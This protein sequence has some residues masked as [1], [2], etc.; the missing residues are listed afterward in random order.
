MTATRLWLLS[1]LA[2]VGLLFA[3]GCSDA[4]RTT[5][6]TLA[7]GIGDG[8]VSGG[9]GDGRGTDPSFS[10]ASGAAP[11]SDDSGEVR[12]SASMGPSVPVDPPVGTDPPQV[13]VSP[14]TLTAGVWDDNRNFD[15]FRDYRTDVTQLGTVG[16]PPF[17]DQQH[18]DAWQASAAELRSHAKLDISLIVDTTGSMGDEMTYLQTE[19]DAMSQQIEAQF[20][21]SQQRWSLVV[22]RDEGDEYVTRWFDFRSDPADFRTHLAAQSANGGGDFPEA[23]DA[24]LGVMNQLA[25]RTDADTARLAFWV[26]DAPHHEENADVLAAGVLNAQ[27]LGIHLYPVASSGVDELTELSMRSAAQLTYGRYIFLTDDSGVGG[28]HKE[29]TIPCYF[30]TQLDHAIMRMVE[31]EMSGTYRQPDTANII[32]TGGDPTDGACSLKSGQTVTIY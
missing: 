24:A 13:Q 14:G 16:L 28:A 26:A 17:T 22:Y 30:V 10:G 4:D 25:W 23:P 19:F 18:I 5:E 21:G 3:V 32:R 20:P 31:I 6:S 7:T 9:G 27:A 1:A 8:E 11:D 2:L 15:H 29:P 12:D